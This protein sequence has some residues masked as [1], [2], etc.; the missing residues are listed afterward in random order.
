ML[1]K[2]WYA[3]GLGAGESFENSL[4]ALPLRAAASAVPP[5]ARD[6]WMLGGS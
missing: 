5:L 1:K 4:L 6:S 3:A 2:T